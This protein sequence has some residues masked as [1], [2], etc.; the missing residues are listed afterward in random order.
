MIFF[1]ILPRFAAANVEKGGV[2]V[3]HTNMIRNIGCA[4]LFVLVVLMAAVGPGNAWPQNGVDDRAEEDFLSI[5]GEMKRFLEEQVMVKK[6]QTERLKA[7]IEVIFDKS[8]L[9]FRYTDSRTYTAAHT[10]GSRSGNCLSFTAMFI[11]MAR[12]VG[13]DAR[14]QE[15][16]HYATWTKREN[17]V[18]FNRH[19]DA[20]VEA[21]GKWVEVDFSFS[22][23]KKFRSSRVVDDSRARAHYY[24]NIGAEALLVK[25]YG[26]AEARLKQAIGQ[27]E[28]FAPAWTNLGLL[29]QHRGRP[30]LAEA[31]YKRAILLDS[32]DTTAAVNLW[33]LYK[34]QGHRQKAA[35]LER[36]IKKSRRKNPFYHYSLGR[37]ALAD[38]KFKEAL[39]H[40]KQAVHKNPREAEFY[41]QLAAACFKLGD[42][43]KA[44]K[45][46]RRAEKLAKSAQDRQRYHQKLQYLYS[47]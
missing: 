47:H 43:S 38:G 4:V 35:Q 3:H 34:K 30:R 29:Y 15:V 46:L 21:D 37:R 31:A 6:G 18:V 11:V 27:D 40:F 8:R 42:R 25:D 16:Y 19:I 2:L 13:L 14:F 24:N 20:L 32:D 33:Q 17:L 12:Y 1:C 22:T 28:G 26:K 10:F 9:D 5:S 39:G 36:R 44:E 23:D 7:L 45:Y 41:S